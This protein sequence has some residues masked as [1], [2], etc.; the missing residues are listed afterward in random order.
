MIAGLFGIEGR[1]PYLDKNTPQEF[2][3]LTAKLKNSCYKN[4]IANF[5]EIHN[6]PFEKEIKIGFIPQKTQ[7]SLKERIEYRLRNM[8]GLKQPNG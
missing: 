2:L 7:F 8:F 3:R 1:Y 6:Y 5:L 4:C